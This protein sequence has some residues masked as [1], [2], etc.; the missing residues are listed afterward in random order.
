MLLVGMV[1]WVCDGSAQVMSGVRI[2]PVVVCTYNFDVHV[3]MADTA[4][5]GCAD[6][7]LGGY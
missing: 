6:H 5:G 7:T 4:L 3:V 1:R 2:M